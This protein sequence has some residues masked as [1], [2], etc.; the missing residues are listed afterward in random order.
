ME[1]HWGFKMSEFTDI[2][3]YVCSACGHEELTDFN[4]CAKCGAVNEVVIVQ[5]QIE[6]GKLT[7]EQN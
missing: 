5:K 4:I 1:F 3:T 6:T 7:K 2:L